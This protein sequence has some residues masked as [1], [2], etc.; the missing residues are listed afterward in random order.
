M[1]L[2]HERKQKTDGSS[3]FLAV[4]DRDAVFRGHAGFCRAEG[5]ES[6]K[7]DDHAVIDSVRNDFIDRG[8]ENRAQVCGGI[9]VLTPEGVETAEQADFLKSKG[10]SEMQGYCFYKPM[11]VEELEK[12]VSDSEN[13]DRKK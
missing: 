7:G 5:E 9:Y 12:I 8:K 10:C 13:A 4:R 6:L 2:N 3:G 1:A 11:P